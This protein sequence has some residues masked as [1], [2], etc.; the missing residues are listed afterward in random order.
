M[1]PHVVL[2]WRAVGDAAYWE[3]G[4][5]AYIGR[6]NCYTI[7]VGPPRGLVAPVCWYHPARRVLPCARRGFLPMRIDPLYPLREGGR[8]DW[9]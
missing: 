8:V 7:A 4:A 3:G 2:R 5:F 6:S 9:L 1:V